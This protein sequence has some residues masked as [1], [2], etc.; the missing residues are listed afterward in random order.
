MVLNSSIVNYNTS[1]HEKEEGLTLHA[2][3]TMGY[4]VP[5][6]R[7]HE[8]LLAAARK[9]ALTEETPGPYVLQTALDDYYARYQINVYTKAVEKVPR[10]YSD[11]Y[12]NLQDGF[13]EAGI[14][15]TAPAYQI[16]LPPEAGG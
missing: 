2:E 13:R 11:L 1:A 12:Q 6:P 3:V 9:T 10:I 5:W 7:V 14:S 16:W 4:A 8:I 15:L